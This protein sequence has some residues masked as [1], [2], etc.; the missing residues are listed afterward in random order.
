MIVIGMIAAQL[1]SSGSAE[2]MNWIFA[3]L[4]NMPLYQSLEA[5]FV[6]GEDFMLTSV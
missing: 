3:K 1:C 2:Q 4:L 6:F 5:L